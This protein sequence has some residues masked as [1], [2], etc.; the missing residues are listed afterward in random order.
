ML[1]SEYYCYLLNHIVGLSSKSVNHYLERKMNYLLTKKPLTRRGFPYI[2][3]GNRTPITRTGIL[4]DILYTT[5]TVLDYL[6]T[7]GGFWQGLSLEFWHK[8]SPGKGV[9]R[10]DWLSLFLVRTEENRVDI[11]EGD[12]IIT[13]FWHLNRGIAFMFSTREET[14]IFKHELFWNAWKAVWLN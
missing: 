5:A 1:R 9:P 11:A 8:K 13:V 2:A 12:S 7:E 3:G 4:C 14:I 10:P 6:T